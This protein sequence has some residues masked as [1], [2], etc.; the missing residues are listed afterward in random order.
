MGL[1]EGVDEVTSEASSRVA[2][3][4]PKPESNKSDQWNQQYDEGRIKKV[5]ERVDH[6]ADLTNKFQKQQENK[7][8]PA[9]KGMRL[10]VLSLACA[11]SD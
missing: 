5:K 2:L 9:K 6:F 1:W 8:K 10:R 7:G 3:M 11:V 4:P